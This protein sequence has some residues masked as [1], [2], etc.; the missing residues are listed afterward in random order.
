MLA[1]H[2]GA[3]SLNF[4][5]MLDNWRIMFLMPVLSSLVPSYFGH[6]FLLEYTTEG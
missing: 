1:M 4:V 6:H 2:S 5:Q 3:V